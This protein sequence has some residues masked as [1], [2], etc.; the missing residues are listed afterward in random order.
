MENPLHQHQSYYHNDYADGYYDDQNQQHQRQYD[1]D[2]A[3]PL[4]GGST[5]TIPETQPPQEEQEPFHPPKI[6]LKHMSMALRLT[7]ECNRRLI[8]GVNRTFNFFHKKN[9]IRNND[10]HQHQQQEPPVSQQQQQ[11]QQQQQP[12]QYYDQ[13]VQQQELQLQ[14]Y[15]NHPVNI[16]PGRTWNPPI[17]EGGPDL[18]QESLTIFHALTPHP[19]EAPEI[20]EEISSETAESESN[21]ESDSSSSSSN[22]NNNNNNKVVTAAPRRGVAYW[23]PELLPYLEE[24]TKLLQ[25]DSNGLEIALAMIYLDRACSVDTIRTN[26]CPPCPFC[27]PRSVHRLS[28]VALILAKQAVNGNSGKT[29][30]EYLQDLKPMGIPLDQLELMANWMMNALGDNGS[31]VTVGQMKV[32]SNNWEAAFFPKRHRA[33]QQQRQKEAQQRLLQL[34]QERLMEHPPPPQ[35]EQPRPE[36]YQQGYKPH[37]EEYQQ[38]YQQPQQQSYNQGYRDQQQEYYQ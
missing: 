5:M 35:P 30:Q 7:C 20:V 24:V 13:Q 21:E 12:D 23:G 34:E 19:E 18:E 3:D 15:G 16:H 32:W 10:A 11:Q 1:H 37:Q 28:L 27:V 29:V 8:A 26:G 31:F 22:N 14:P 17:P 6:L 9:R 33:L 2:T 38:G 36:Q 4:R 25:I